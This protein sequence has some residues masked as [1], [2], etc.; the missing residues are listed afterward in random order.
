[1]GAEL[2][3]LKKVM[4]WLLLNQPLI[5]NQDVV[6]LS[7]SKSGIMALENHH[8]WSYSSITNQIWNLASILKDSMSSN[9]SVGSKSRGA[10]R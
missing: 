10:E 7:D 5:L 1:M 4:D 2:F 6:I 3:A 9:Y 8:K